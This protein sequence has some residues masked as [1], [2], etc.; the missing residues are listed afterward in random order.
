MTIDRRL[1]VIARKFN[2]IFYSVSIPEWKLYGRRTLVIISNDEMKENFPMTGLFDDVI[3]FPAE[4]KSVISLYRLIREIYSCS[5]RILSDTVVLSNPTM[6]I[7]QY[8]IS[9]S[10]CR[11]IIFVEDGLMNY[12]KYVP[13]KSLKKLVINRL[14]NLD[15]SSILSKIAKTYISSPSLA[16][17]YFGQL[18]G[19]KINF[20]LIEKNIR[21]V[22][23]LS[24][25]RIFV[26]QDLYRWGHCTVDEY[27]QL[28]N[29][30]IEKYDID[31]YI[32]HA[33]ASD[34]ETVMGCQCFRIID[35]TLEVLASKYDFEVFSFNSS[36]LFTTKIINPRIKSHAVVSSVL[37]DMSLPPILEQCCDDIL[38]AE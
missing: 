12:Y 2:D 27:N 34:A 15:S 33:F 9:V 18:S 7:N 30:I 25:K 21:P 16:V 4:T 19:L 31:L 10:G 32:P 8:I 23:D 14:L 28:I 20:D 13:R 6:A 29:R 1:L 5:Q 38:N 24:G 22:D 37:N 26:G 35:A 17:Y 36:V 11:D 3:Y